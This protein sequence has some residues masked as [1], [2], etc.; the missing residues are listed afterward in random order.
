MTKSPAVAVVFALALAPSAGAQAPAD[1]TGLWGATLR[2][3]P[4]IGG[5]LL[6]YRTSDGW[7]ADIAGFTVP[8]RIDG[9]GLRAFAFELPDKK[10]AFRGGH[11][12]QPERFATPVTLVANGK[13]RWRGTVTPLENRL[14]F[15]L[16]IAR[17]LHTYLRNPER[18]IGRFIR[19]THVTVN[20]KDVRLLDR[21][22]TTLARGHYED[23]VISVPLR[24]ATY[25]FTRV[26]DTAS[27]PF[28]PRGRPATRYRYTPPLQLNDGWPVAQPESVGISRDQVQR[29]VQQFLDMPMD[30]LNTIQIHSLLIARHGK[31]VLEE[32][33]HGYGRDT[34][35]DLRSA[36]KS[37]TATLIG[38]AMQAGVPLTVNTPVY[39]T[40][41]DS[42]P[43]NLDPQKRAMTLEHLLTMTAGFNCDEDDPTSADEDQMSGQDSIVDWV[44]HTLEVRLI[45]APG[46]KIFYCSAEPNVAAG[47]LAKV[48]HEHLPEMF[49]RLIARPLHMR[50]YHLGLTPLGEAYGGGGHRF[51]PRDFLKFAQLMVNEGRWEGKQIV[52]REWARQSTSPLRDFTPKLH[53][54]YLWN[55]GDYQYRGRSVLAFW[56]GGNG[57]QVFMGIPELDL[58]IG[59]TGGNYNDGV[60][61]SVPDSVLSVVR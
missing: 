33:F 16:P 43:A 3:G 25:D 44:R 48:A 54:G 50:G 32:Y 13:D 30:S 2:F 41:L 20:G 34:P 55:A 37:W 24:G 22:D 36:S 28:Y 57:G 53:W 10:G 58:V 15:Y 49:E 19:V 51:T 38:A 21:S 7:R 60:R 1:L 40:M 56:A 35:H 31:L 52:S 5:T 39:Q 18:N 26:A 4:D 23:G 29:L 6:I 59:F 9:Q 45:S 17:D 27:S 42:V 12:I 11:W 8:V 61:Y 46:E 14:T 47:M